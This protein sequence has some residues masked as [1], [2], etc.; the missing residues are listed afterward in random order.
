MTNADA[1]AYSYTIARMDDE[2]HWVAI[3]SFDSY[4]E[5]DLVLDKYADMY[6]S[7][8]VDIIHNHQA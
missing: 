6:P 8:I 7:T 4:S 1:D 5:A 2:G 3:D